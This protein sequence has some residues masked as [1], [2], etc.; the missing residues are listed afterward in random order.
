[1]AVKVKDFM[2][3]PVVTT[4]IDADAAYARE[5][6]E[7]KDVS[8]IPVIELEEEHMEIRGI[9]S[10]YD[11]TGI[12][13]E[14]IPVTEIMSTIVQIVD[15]EMRATDAATVM[16][17]HGIHHLVV[18]NRGRIVGMLSSLDFVRLIADEA[19]DPAKVAGSSK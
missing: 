17:N 8:A 15:P 4:T 11:L 2:S 3:A 14:S 16:I 6:M 1:M 13:D 18:M 7:R 10:L 9:L 12:G 5:L 19:V